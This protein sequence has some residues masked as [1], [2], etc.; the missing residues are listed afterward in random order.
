MSLDISESY[1][2]AFGNITFNGH[3]VKVDLLTFF[4]DQKDHQKVFPR[5][6]GRM[7]TS[8]TAISQLRD[9]L[10]KMIDDLEKAE[11]RNK[12]KLK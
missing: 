7:V 9:G 8:I 12:K 5:L 4:P 10:N 2:D 3:I 6:T 1:V 11:N